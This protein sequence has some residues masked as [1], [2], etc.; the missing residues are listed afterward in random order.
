M[1]KIRFRKGKK[2]KKYKDSRIDKLEK[3]LRDEVVM[4]G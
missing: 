2:T 4:M 1:Q 3:Q